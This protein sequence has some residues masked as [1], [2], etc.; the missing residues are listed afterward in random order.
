[1]NY[2][3][4]NSAFLTNITDVAMPPQSKIN[5]TPWII[6]GAIIFVTIVVSILVTNEY[7]KKTENENATKF[8]TT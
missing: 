2:Y 8:S 3:L 5:Y 4:D 7:K 1:M 6:C